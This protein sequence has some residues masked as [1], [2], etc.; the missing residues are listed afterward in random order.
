MTDIYEKSQLMLCLMVKEWRLTHACNST[1]VLWAKVLR[2][3]CPEFSYCLRT[4]STFVLWK[5]H[6]FQS[7][8]TG[9]NFHTTWFQ[10]LGLHVEYVF[11]VLMSQLLLLKVQN[12]QMLSFS[13][14]I[15]GVVY[16]LSFPPCYT[17]RFLRVVTSYKV[18]SS[19]RLYP[20]CMAMARSV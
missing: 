1:K 18:V 7:S 20:S 12:R 11:M 9:R 14:L 5:P 13:G 2:F 10:M 19:Y 6:I 4:Y 8:Y 17:D 3:I 15:N 16:F